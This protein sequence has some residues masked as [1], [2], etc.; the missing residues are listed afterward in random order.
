MK[1]A[2]FVLILKYSANVSSNFKLLFMS[3]ISTYCFLYAQSVVCL[4][5]FVLYNNFTKYS[6]KAYYRITTFDQ[7]QTKF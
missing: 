2:L 5:N 7:K 1:P 3:S 4:H 6:V